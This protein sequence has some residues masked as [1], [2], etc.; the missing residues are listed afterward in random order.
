M[1]SMRLC[2]QCGGKAFAASPPLN[3]A[4]TSAPTAARMQPIHS[5]ISSPSTVLHPARK[6]EP[7]GHWRRF[8]AALLDGLILAFLGGLVFA[9]ASVLGSNAG[10][11]KLAPALGLILWVAFPYIYF[12]VLHAG[13]KSASWGKAAVGLIVVTQQG[14]R[15]TKWQAFIR[16]LLQFLLPVAAYAVLFITF[17]S[18]FTLANEEMKTIMGLAI[19]IGVLAIMFGPFLTVFFNPQHQTLF[20]LIC[21]TRVVKKPTP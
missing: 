4:P 20:D 15:L 10:G 11:I 14:E 17:G 8:F 7:A 18:A 2:P 12:T 6:F 3:P 9:L 1:P 16:I 13:A 19:I 21:K 5:S